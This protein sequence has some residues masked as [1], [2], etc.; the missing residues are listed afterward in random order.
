MFDGF[1]VVIIGGGAQ[2]A[3]IRIRKSKRRAKG[4]AENV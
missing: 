3:D 2:P 1:R 4:E